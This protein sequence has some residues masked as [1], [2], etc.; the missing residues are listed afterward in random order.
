MPNEIRA[1]VRVVRHF[2]FSAE[3]VFDAWLDP[4]RV[5]RWLFATSSGEIVRVKID[6]RVGGGF[7]IVDRRAGDDVEHQGEYLEVDRPKRLVFKFLVPKYSPLYSRVAIDIVPA[8]GGCDLTLVHEGVLSEYEEQTQSGW[9]AILE[10]LAVELASA[11][12]T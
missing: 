3:R 5:G 11:V 10:K 8:G 2:E 7:V 12:R 1:T 9:T 4:Q 6:A